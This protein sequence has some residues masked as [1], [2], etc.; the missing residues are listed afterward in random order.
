MN[1]ARIRAGWNGLRNLIIYHSRR[2]GFRSETLG[3]SKSMKF[4]VALA[5]L[6]QSAPVVS[7]P[8]ESFVPL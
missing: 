1:L 4:A 5:V 2:E 7:K 3:K 8:S 6:I